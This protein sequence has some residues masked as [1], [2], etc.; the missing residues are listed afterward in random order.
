MSLLQDLNSW[1]SDD[2]QDS[3][4]AGI[5]SKELLTMSAAVA[6]PGRYLT[7]SHTAN[8][9]GSSDDYS[10]SEDSSGEDSSSS[11][12]TSE[13]DESSVSTDSEQKMLE[14]EQEE[15]KRDLLEEYSQFSE[16]TQEVKQE[17]TQETPFSIENKDV[18]KS[19]EV[20]PLLVP[21]LS[22]GEDATTT[23]INE[24]KAK[25]I[26]LWQQA[27]AQSTVA[28]TVS[29]DKFDIKKITRPR[30]PLSFPTDTDTQRAHASIIVKE[31]KKVTNSGGSFVFDMLDK[32]NNHPNEAPTAENEA[33]YMT[34]VAPV[35]SQSK[36]EDEIK[37]D[38][39]ISEFAPD[40]ASVELSENEVA[41]PVFSPQIAPTSEP[42]SPLQSP[43]VAHTI[44]K[45]GSP[46]QSPQVAPTSEPIL[47]MPLS[48]LDEFPSNS[49][50][51]KTPKSKQTGTNEP[52]I[53]S[54]AVLK[55]KASTRQTTTKGAKKISQEKSI[56]F[57]MQVPKISQEL[58][59]LG[60]FTNTQVPKI[61]RVLPDPN[62]RHIPLLK[63]AELAPNPT[64]HPLVG[65]S[66]LNP[67]PIAV[68][69]R[70]D[71]PKI[72]APP[73][74]DKKKTL[75]PTV[76]LPIQ[77]PQEHTTIRQLPNS[78]KKVQLSKS[79]F[80]IPRLTK[81]KEKKKKQL[82]PT[83]VLKSHAEHKKAVP[84]KS[85]LILTP[86]PTLPVPQEEVPA[87][88]SIPSAPTL[89]LDNTVSSDVATEYS[90][91]PEA[92]SQ[93]H[94]ETPRVILKTKSS[95]ASAEN[96]P[97]N[98]QDLERSKKKPPH[99]AV[100]VWRPGVSLS[101][102]FKELDQFWEFDKKKSTAPEPQHE[103]KKGANAKITRQTTARKT[104]ADSQDSVNNVKVIQS[105]QSPQPLAVR[106]GLRAPAL[107]VPVLQ[108][109][110]TPLAAPVV[111][112]LEFPT[113]LP[114]QKLKSKKKENFSQ[115]EKKQ[116]TNNEVFVEQK[117][118][119]CRKVVDVTHLALSMS[120]MAYTFYLY[121]MVSESKYPFSML[122]SFF[123]ID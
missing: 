122:A 75:Q 4:N 62:I 33:A 73:V 64:P 38:E 65:K 89:L 96:S 34:D 92:P 7:P 32:F 67:V 58:K 23:T 106:S 82:T 103:K 111:Y 39:N 98:I 54:A 63:V 108:P 27:P 28:S 101:S 68:P 20:N 41:S 37:L 50:V 30:I 113:V 110:S 29:T 6:T 24:K 19:S 78:A 61:S 115:V 43:Q 116:Q 5:D 102:N 57:D 22:E 74:I 94:K 60:N 70:P 93:K 52:L 12:A 31:Y 53:S 2:D 36:Q 56:Q 40:I 77:K 100:K 25:E 76:V 69:V 112:P 14:L 97:D 59:P 104:K 84:I 109:P 99:T 26:P 95:P 88:S 91:I 8:P 3:L 35:P 71:A 80:T 55:P 13:T 49:S 9:S 1:D 18:T 119:K 21:H 47:T 79:Q 81:V 17:R 45:P 107:K 83:V 114:K 10:S 11:S 121:T 15:N 72:V 66:I 51:V 118:T 48:G 44:P 123:S 86:F 90:K 16:H 105:P 42:H 85:S 87:K 117:D 120:I 46:L